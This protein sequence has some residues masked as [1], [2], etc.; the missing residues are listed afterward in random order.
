MEN[1]IGRDIL[2]K[3]IVKDF[4]FKHNQVEPTHLYFPYK[5]VVCINFYGNNYYKLVKKFKTNTEAE[6]QIKQWKLKIDYFVTQYPCEIKF[7]YFKRHNFYN[8]LHAFFY[9]QQNIQN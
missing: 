3:R 1:E 2:L 5:A 9:K 6:N 8:I 7:K 4:D